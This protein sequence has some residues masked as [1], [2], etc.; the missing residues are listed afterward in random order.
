MVSSQLGVRGLDKTRIADSRVV[1]DVV[2][3]AS[4]NVLEL[5]A[6]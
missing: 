2:R 6:L 1:A 5:F 3:N 4:G